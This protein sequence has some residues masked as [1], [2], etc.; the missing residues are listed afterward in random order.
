MPLDPKVQA[1]LDMMAAANMPKIGSI[2]AAE[3]RRLQATVQASMPP[4]PDIYKVTDSTIPTKNGGIPIRTYLPSAAPT[5][6]IVYYHGGG[7]TLGSLDGYDTPLRK[8]AIKSGAAIISVDYRLAPEHRFPAAVEDALSALH[9]IGINV[10][11]IAGKKVPLF[12]SGDSAGGNLS[13]VVAQIVR[14][15]GGPDI[16]GQILLYPSTDGD[17]G[18]SYMTKFVSPFLTKEEISWFYDQYIPDKAM[19]SDPRFAPVHASSLAGLP[20]AFILTAEYDLLCEE[21]E[22]YAQK[23]KEAGVPVRLKRYLG[24]IH[25]FFSVDGGLE[26][27]VAATDD[28]A[29]F[30][31]NGV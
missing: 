25:G 13:A 2:S 12:V 27:S 5:A 3:F 29:S 19:R 21:A 23:L 9:W 18:S 15:E 7:W 8:L 6:L 11:K 28:I 16:A 26:H 20:P 1:L 31:K 24:T 30:I 17:I 22:I 4:G 14:D 10:A